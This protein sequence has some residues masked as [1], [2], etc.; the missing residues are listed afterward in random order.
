MGHLSII[1]FVSREMLDLFVVG[2]LVTKLHCMGMMQKFRNNI[3]SPAGVT[4]TF[5]VLQNFERDT[6]FFTAVVRNV[7]E[8]SPDFGGFGFVPQSQIAVPGLNLLSAS[9]VAPRGPRMEFVLG[10][11]AEQEGPVYFSVR[12]AG[13][14]KICPVRFLG[15]KHDVISPSQKLTFLNIFETKFDSM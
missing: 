11:N 5:A 7:N 1:S 14:R 10:S 8:M 3:W 15:C 2:A 4:G 9:I 12:A 13:Q 6:V